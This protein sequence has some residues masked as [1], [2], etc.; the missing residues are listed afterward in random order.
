MLKCFAVRSVQWIDES[1]M[2]GAFCV[3]ERSMC[4]TKGYT[5]RG[6]AYAVVLGVTSF[7]SSH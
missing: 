3:I 1:F 4:S 6:V 5:E 2:C 7:S